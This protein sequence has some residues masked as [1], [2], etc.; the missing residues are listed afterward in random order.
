M[1]LDQLAEVAESGSDSKNPE[2][3][4]QEVILTFSRNQRWEMYTG[5]KDADGTSDWASFF[6]FLG[7]G[8]EMVGKRLAKQEQ[9]LEKKHAELQDKNRQMEDQRAKIELS[10]DLILQL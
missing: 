5:E 1:I 6:S 4:L 10:E 9:A 7:S 2:R 8:V 3:L